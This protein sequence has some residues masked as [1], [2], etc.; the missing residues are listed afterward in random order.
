V[1]LT[2]L[3]EGEHPSLQEENIAPREHANEG[4]YLWIFLAVL[5]I[6]ILYFISKQ[7]LKKKK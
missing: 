4:S 1:D 7:I 6:N 2:I 3:G 5:L